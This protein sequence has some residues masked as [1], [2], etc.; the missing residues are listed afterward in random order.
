MNRAFI[1]TLALIAM[2]AWAQLQPSRASAA[3]IAN[4]KDLLFLCS[5]NGDS[6]IELA[7]YS[8]CMGYISAVA[9]IMLDRQSVDG[10][11]SCDMRGITVGRSVDITLKLLRESPAFLH[12]SAHSLVALALSEAFPCRRR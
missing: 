11:S 8:M 1:A 6:S 7:Q 4:G 10:M 12:H 5:Q 2:G 9:Q 3:G